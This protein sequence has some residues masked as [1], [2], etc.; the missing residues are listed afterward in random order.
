L[1]LKTIFARFK[2]H[3]GYV[4]VLLAAL[5]VCTAAPASAQVSSDST[6]HSE[7]G[8]QIYKSA[9]IACHGPDG[10]GTPKSIAGF[11]QPRTFPDFTR[12]DQTTPEA[13]SAWRA[14]IVHGGPN[15]G[16][17]QI[18]PSFGEALSASQIN[19]V[20]EYMRGFC[21]KAG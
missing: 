19:S 5:V 10:T 20:I 14:V 12:C 3:P 2:I 1:E 9:C 4:A 13:N 15:R 8:Q 7:S 21:R 11:E 18:M 6:L 16:F 17:S